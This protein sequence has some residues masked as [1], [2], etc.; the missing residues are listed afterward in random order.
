MSDPQMVRMTHTLKMI[1]QDV[2]LN[3]TNYEA[4]NTLVYLALGTA[5]GMGLKV[6]IRVDDG[7]PVICIE[8]PTGEVSWHHKPYEV[9]FSGYDTAEKY[10]RIREYVNQK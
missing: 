1:L 9:P 7:W 10:R 3:E 4:R 5:A 8:L 6:G 2:E